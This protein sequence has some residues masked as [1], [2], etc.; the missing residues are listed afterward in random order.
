MKK[1]KKLRMQ[2]MTIFF[3]FISIV[4]VFEPKRFQ[5]FGTTLIFSLFISTRQY[6]KIID[7]YIILQE[8]IYLIKTNYFTCVL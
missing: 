8:S 2:I 3:I 5:Q 6:L 4:H 1:E 7:A